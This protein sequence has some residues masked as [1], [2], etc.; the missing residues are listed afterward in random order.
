M[1]C[2][3]SHRFRSIDWSSR[4]GRYDRHDNYCEPDESPGCLMQRS[5]E[6]RK[7]HL[8][9]C[10]G[11]QYLNDRRGESSARCEHYHT[12]FFTLAHRDRNSHQVTEKQKRD[13]AM[14]DLYS[15]GRPAEVDCPAPWKTAARCRCVWHVRCKRTHDERDNGKANG[16]SS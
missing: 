13:H 12:G 1:S 10:C 2:C 11:D 9:H 14:D 15:E 8:D 3:R 4:A 16:P 6:R 7:V 5:Q